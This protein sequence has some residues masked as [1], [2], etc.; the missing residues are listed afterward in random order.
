MT[1]DE[2]LAGYLDRS[3]SEDQLL[4]FEARMANDPTFAA[5]AKDLAAVEKLLA[6]SAPKVVPPPG[7]LS[8]V[9]AT[10]VA[11][12]A[13][14]TAGAI[15]LGH[16]ASNMWA[17][18]I[19]SSTVLIGA[20]GVYLAMTSHT[21]KAE[22]ASAIPQKQSAHQE[23]AP[24]LHLPPDNAAEPVPAP[25]TPGT[26][27]TVTSEVPT[28]LPERTP[29]RR[30]DDSRTIATNSSPSALEQLVSKYEQCTS[31]GTAI[32]CAHLALNIGMQYK[33]RGELN[34]AFQFFERALIQARSA[35][36]VQQQ[37]QAL[38]EMARIS[39][40]TDDAESARKHYRN[41]IDLAEQNGLPSEQLTTEL[42]ELE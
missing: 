41:A 40:A 23:I 2:L 10:V 42:N 20:G 18:I 19:G 16:L 29:V 37:V 27:R 34:N 26:S 24:S 12:I 39:R 15:G 13:A 17:W 7:F 11:K 35:R 38:T 28:A 33:Q 5:E 14:G 25:S 3:L 6:T 21:P 4:E 1:N 8:S 30:S 22:P 32:N 9:E 36:T 31:E